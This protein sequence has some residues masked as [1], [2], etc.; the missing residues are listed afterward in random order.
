[1]KCQQSLCRCRCRYQIWVTFLSRHQIQETNWNWAS[2]PVASTWPKMFPPNLR[3]WNFGGLL[4]NHV[5]RK[6]QHGD[7]WFINAL[8]CHHFK[9]KRF[10]FSR[11]DLHSSLVTLS[12][13]LLSK[14]TY[15]RGEANAG[16]GQS[17]ALTEHK[18]ITSGLNYL[19]IT[20]RVA[21]CHCASHNR[22]K[23]VEN[24]F[25]RRGGWWKEGGGMG[26]D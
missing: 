13:S 24:V 14:A 11:P 2:T 5:G 18:C 1:M 15:I 3:W 9:R 8:A 7:P 16:Q 19:G 10:L 20:R 6:T 17:F 26:G 21:P 4:F 12:L 22:F 25:R 23:Q